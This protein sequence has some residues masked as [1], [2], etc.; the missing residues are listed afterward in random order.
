MRTLLLLFMLALGQTAFAACDVTITAGDGIAYDKT[1]IEV[2][3]SCESVTVTLKHTGSLPRNA[4]G[5]NW[6][7]SKSG[8]LD[9]VAQAGLGAGLENNYVPPGDARVLAN[10]TVVGGGEETSVTF[11][12]AE[13]PDAEYAFFCSFPG[14]WAIMKGV[15]KIT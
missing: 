7:L 13:L 15:L 14:H 1:I 9:A 8:D 5:H 12:L 3:R 2:E 6:V 11:S 10:T 4:M